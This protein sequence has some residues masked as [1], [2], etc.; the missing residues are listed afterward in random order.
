MVFVKFN[1]RLRNKLTLKNRDPLCAY[2]DEERVTDWLVPPKRNGGPHIDSDDEVFPGEGL[3][4]RQVAKSMG[5][6]PKRRKS[7]RTKTYK[8]E[9]GTKGASSS[10]EK[11]KELT[12][13][14]DEEEF[15]STESSSE[16]DLNI[17]I[18]LEEEDS[19]ESEHGEA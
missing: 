16:E 9:K 12:R 7:V 15:S 6:N 18:P 10:K 8:R 13:E 5:A 2:D 4:W 3:S 11:S 14:E 1:A 19:S 17:D